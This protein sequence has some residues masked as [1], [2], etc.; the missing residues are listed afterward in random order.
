MGVAVESSQ[1]TSSATTHAIAPIERVAGWDT[2][3]P[4]PGLEQQY[5]PSVARILARPRRAL[6][7]GCGVGRTC[8]ALRRHFDEV[9]GLDLAEGK[10]RNN[11]E[12][13]VLEPMVSKI[14][15]LKFA[16]EASISILRIDEMIK[17]AP[18]QED[19]PQRHC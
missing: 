6:D 12:H 17:L 11:L 10:V 13:G 16:T 1:P 7:F 4:L 2:V 9:L 18:E 5:M 19:A 8:S 15:S 14:K 3:M